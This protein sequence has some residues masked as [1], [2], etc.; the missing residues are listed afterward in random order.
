MTS[1][2]DYYID[3]E[4][5]DGVWTV[6]T[7]DPDGGTDHEAPFPTRTDAVA[8]AREIASVLRIDGYTVT[9]TRSRWVAS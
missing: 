9:H 2:A 3:V 6:W 1:R 4:N 8:R 5:D 7:H